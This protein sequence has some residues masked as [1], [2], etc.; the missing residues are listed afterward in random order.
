[1]FAVSFTKQAYTIE[2]YVCTDCGDPFIL[3]NKTLQR[4]QTGYKACSVRA[5]T[6]LL[7]LIK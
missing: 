5:L 7:V 4:C 6:I 1:L 3:Q 2:C